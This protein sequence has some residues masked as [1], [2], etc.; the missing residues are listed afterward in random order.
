MSEIERRAKAIVEGI[1]EEQRRAAEKAEMAEHLRQARQAKRDE[2]KAAWEQVCGLLHRAAAEVEAHLKPVGLKIE[3]SRREW[4]SEQLLASLEAR[5]FENGR[6]TQ[7][8]LTFDVTALGRIT[9]KPPL[10]RGGK[11]IEFEAR[12]ADHEK[13]AGILLDFIEAARAGRLPSS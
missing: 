3:F 1:Q 11:L 13:L 8:H 9:V 4:D 2:V 5:L 10:S 6:D 12:D 7:A